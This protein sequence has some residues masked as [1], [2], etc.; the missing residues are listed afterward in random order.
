MPEN[1]AHDMSGFSG[2][3]RDRDGTVLDN[4][5]QPFQFSNPFPQIHDAQITHGFQPG[6]PPGMEL[7]KGE[8]AGVLTDG[9]FRLSFFPPI[10]LA[11]TNIFQDADGIAGFVYCKAKVALRHESC[12]GDKHSI[13]SEIP[14]VLYN[15]V[16]CVSPIQTFLRRGNGLQLSPRQLFEMQL[17]AARDAGLLPQVDCLPRHA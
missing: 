10:K 11:T 14:G 9:H 16:S 1:I 7:E 2:A 4:E 13:A 5:I 17:A 8:E 12:A 6:N 15:G 3:R